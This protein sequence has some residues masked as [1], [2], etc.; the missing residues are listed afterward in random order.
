MKKFYYKKIKILN[1]SYNQIYW[2]GKI[3]QDKI[4]KDN[5]PQG[6][7]D[8]LNNAPYFAS[9]ANFWIDNKDIDNNNIKSYIKHSIELRKENIEKN[10]VFISDNNNKVKS[11]FDLIKGKCK[12]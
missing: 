1:G 3:M 7:V 2:A 12:Y 5:D 6:F 4:D 11:Q 9:D 10:K 8:L